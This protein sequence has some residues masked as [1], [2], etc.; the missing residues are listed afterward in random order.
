MLKQYSSKSIF[1]AVW[2]E[3]AEGWRK[4][5]MNLMSRSCTKYCKVC[6]IKENEV[7]KGRGKS[8]GQIFVLVGNLKERATWKN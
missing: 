4:L 7:A 6:R 5:C 3:I 1:I 2:D 8:L